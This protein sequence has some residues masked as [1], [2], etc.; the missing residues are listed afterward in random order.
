MVS[1]VELLVVVTDQLKIVSILARNVP[2]V[3]RQKRLDNDAS[4]LSILLLRNLEI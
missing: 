2:R 1:L 3:H 4:L